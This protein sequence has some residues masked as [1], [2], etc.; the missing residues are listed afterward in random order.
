MADERALVVRREYPVVKVVP[1]PLV[2]KDLTSTLNSETLTAEFRGFIRSQLDRNKSGDPGTKLKM[3]VWLDLV[4]H[5]EKM[6]SLAESDVEERTRLMVQVGT[7]FLAK[8]PDGH[9]IALSGAQGRRDLI[10]HCE[11]IRIGAV[12][13]PD[14]ELLRTA[15][16]NFV[17]TKLEQKH[18]LWKKIR[19][20][21]TRLHALICSL[22]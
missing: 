11:A 14:L 1:P 19:N 17:W 9:N 6:F 8:P 12:L 7:V 15:A 3:E 13:D 10:A 20:P 2:V 4:L 22:M 21:P 18:D 16:Y 5:C